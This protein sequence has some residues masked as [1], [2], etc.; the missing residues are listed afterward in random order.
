DRAED[1]RGRDVLAALAVLVAG[2]GH[3]VAAAP[4]QH[5]AVALQG[6]GGDRGEIV[7]SR[8]GQRAHGDRAGGGVHGAGAHGDVDPVGAR[9]A[10]QPDH[11]GE[12]GRGRDGGRDDRDR[13]DLVLLA[14]GGG[15]VG[16]DVLDGQRGVI[17]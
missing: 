16:E 5:D 6:G 14:G 3:A 12:R 10:A 9:L 17:E 7:R 1:D 11:A 8:L 2:R 4:E 15:G 13:R